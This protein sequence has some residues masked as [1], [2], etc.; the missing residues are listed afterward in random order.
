MS[1]NVTNIHI[2]TYHIKKGTRILDNEQFLF[3]QLKSSVVKS[4]SLMMKMITYSSFRQRG[5]I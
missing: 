1:L 2:H 4:K 3:L 5:G